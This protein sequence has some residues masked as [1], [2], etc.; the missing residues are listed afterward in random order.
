M[1]AELC[2]AFNLSNPSSDGDKRKSLAR[3]FNSFNSLSACFSNCIISRSNSAFIPG[4]QPNSLYVSINEV[5]T[6]DT[7]LSPGL[8]NEV[9]KNSLLASSMSLIAFIILIS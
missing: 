6:G 3:L 2:L 1:A 7:D 8:L 9:D 4:P 5:I